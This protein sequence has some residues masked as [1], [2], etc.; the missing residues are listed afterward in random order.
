MCCIVFQQWIWEGTVIRSI[1]KFY[2]VNFTK[3]RPDYSSFPYSLLRYT[4]INC[5]G[6]CNTLPS[7]RLQFTKRPEY[8]SP[9]PIFHWAHCTANTYLQHIIMCIV[10]CIYIPPQIYSCSCMQYIYEDDKDAVQWYAVQCCIGHGSIP[11]I[12]HKRLSIG[13]AG[14]ARQILYK[15]F[16]LPTFFLSFLQFRFENV[17]L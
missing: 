17:K 3:N 11:P 1:G 10:H 16:K 2:L 13:G 9:D 8:S 7:T 6:T 12:R 4:A 15:F 5:W 14:R